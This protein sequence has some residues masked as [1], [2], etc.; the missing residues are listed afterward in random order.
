M[1]IQPYSDSPG[2]I[3][4]HESLK[5]A[6]EEVEKRRQD[7]RAACLCRKHGCASSAGAQLFCCFVVICSV[8]LALIDFFSIA[9]GRT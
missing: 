7:V 4:L 3:V 1:S 5:L 8:V 6:P 2:D 9:G